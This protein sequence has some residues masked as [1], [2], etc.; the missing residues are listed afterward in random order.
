V[1]FGRKGN[2]RYWWN[3]G[4]WGNREHGIE[5]NQTPVGPRVRGTIETGRWYEI[6]VQLEGARIR[7]FLNGE[8][9][10]NTIAPELR[11]LYTSAGREKTS[12]DLIVKTINCGDSPI[13]ANLRMRGLTARGEGRISVLT[14]ENRSDN[15]SLV[16]PMK[17]IPTER[18]IDHQGQ[19]FQNEFPAHSLTVLRLKT[20]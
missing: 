11:E 20:R 7:C 13:V 17:V 1:V 4:G 9:I 14:S 19:E 16:E 8:M 6:K 3:L 18:P 15:N 10:H 2:D 12:G 5:F